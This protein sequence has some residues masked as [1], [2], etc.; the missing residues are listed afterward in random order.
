MGPTFAGAAAALAVGEAAESTIESGGRVLGS[1]SG[2]AASALAV[3]GAVASAVETG[4][5]PRVPAVR[6]VPGGLRGRALEALAGEGGVK[7]ERVPSTPGSV[8]FGNRGNHGKHA[9]ECPLASAR[10]VGAGLSVAR[11]DTGSLSERARRSDFDSGCRHGATDGE[12]VHAQL[13]L[14]VEAWCAAQDSVAHS[15]STGSANIDVVACAGSSLLRACDGSVKLFTSAVGSARIAPHIHPFIVRH[16][17]GTVKKFPGVTLLI[18]LAPG[19]PVCVARGGYPTAEH[20]YANHPSVAPHAVVVH[21]NICADVVHGRALVF[22][23]TSASDIRGLRVPSLAVVLKPKFCII[24]DLTF[25]RTGGHSSITND[26]DLSSAPSCEPGHVLR[27]VL[28][29][30]LFLRQIHGPTAKIVLFHVDMKYAFRQVLVDPVEAPVFLYAM[31]SYVVVN[32]RLQFGWRNSPGFWGLMASALE[33]VHTHSTFQ[34]LAVSPQG[35]AAVEHVR[36][37]PLRRGSV[38]SLPRNCRPVSGSDGYAGSCFFVRYYVDD[39]ILAE[40]QW[41][42][43][44]RRSMRAA[45]SRWRRT[46][47]ACWAYV[48][49]PTLLFCPPAKSLTGTRVSKCWAG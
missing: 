22:R 47:F 43:D 48:A 16:W 33:H 9:R 6:G 37:A 39:G 19:S 25:A 34:D 24:D 31:G 40:V 49:R 13:D 20:A 15:V 36:H 42:P 1:S 38:R 44:G 11:G 23:L 28:L 17:F 30:V 12:R 3:G 2:I 14:A 4:G 29:R 8:V 10:L 18:V 27:D 46:T 45:R 7:R 26:T 32:L 35:A 5:A 21:Q 41:W